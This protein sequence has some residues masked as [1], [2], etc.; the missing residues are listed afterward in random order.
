MNFDIINWLSN[1]LTNRAQKCTVNGLTSGERPILCGVPQGSILGPL[2]FLLFIND[3]DSNFVHSNVL[4]YADDTVI[5]AAHEDELTA[6][7]WMS[8]DLSVL[9]KWCHKN[10]LTINLKK[11]KVMLFGTRNML[12]NCKKGDTVM[13]DCKIQYVNHFNYLGIKLDRT[14]TFE[15]HACETIRMVAHKLYL[16]S[17]VRKYINIQQAITIYRSMIVPYFDYGDIFLSNINLKTIDKLQKLQNRALRICLAL[18]GRSNVNELHNICNINK[19]SHRRHVHLLNFSF[20][21]AQDMRFLKEGNRALR[22]YDAPVLNE[23]KSN[24]KSFERSLLY[25]CAQN[26]NA[27]P[28]LERNIKTAKEFKKKQKCK[29]NE[30]LPYTI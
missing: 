17:R 13:N 16:L 15:M 8:E 21:R 27:L 14:L 30:L 2:L 1:Y 11:T 18:D 9:C 10:Q 5:Y 22:R 7:L 3:I 12:K 19:L 20:H 29:L 24:N 28:A 25:Q 4:L 6:H 23:L 26:W